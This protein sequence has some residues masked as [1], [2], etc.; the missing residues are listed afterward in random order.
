[1]KLQ[2]WTTVDGHAEECLGE[3]DVDDEQWHYAQACAGDAYELITDLA[4]ECQGE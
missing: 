3:I 2:L 4:N 1:M